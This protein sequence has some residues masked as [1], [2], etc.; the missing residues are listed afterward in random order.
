MS[1]CVTSEN[2]HGDD[3]R[4]LEQ[5]TAGG[6][7][8]SMLINQFI[9]VCNCVVVTVVLCILLVNSPMTNDNR[10]IIRCRG[11]QWVK[12]MIS[13]APHRPLM[14]PADGGSNQRHLCDQ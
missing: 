13:H 5:V 3:Q 9:G 11:E 6:H 2:L 4:V 14:V 1:D 10:S 12:P 7:T 8:T